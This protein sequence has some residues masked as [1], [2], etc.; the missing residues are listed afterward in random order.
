MIHCLKGYKNSFHIEF[1][2]YN[3]VFVYFPLRESGVKLSKGVRAWHTL[4]TEYSLRLKHFSVGTGPRE[5]L[6]QNDVEGTMVILFDI[7]S[8]TVDSS[9]A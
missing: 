7:G 6:V 4:N 1:I 9:G 2:T 8:E 3:I 5:H